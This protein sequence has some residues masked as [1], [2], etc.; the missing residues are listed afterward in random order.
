M[1]FLT[2]HTPNGKSFRYELAAQKHR[3]GRSSSNDLIFEQKDPAASRF[4]AEVVRRPD[5]FYVVDLKAR[6]GTYVNDRRIS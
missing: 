4:H 3:M 2:I 6:N 1:D 5:G